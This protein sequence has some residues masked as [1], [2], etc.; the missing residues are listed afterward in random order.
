MNGQEVFEQRLEK[1][2]IEGVGA[3]GPGVG[4]I[5]VDFNKQAVDA[6]GDSGARQQRNKLRLAA[7]D[8]IGCR[9]LLHGV[10]RIEDDGRK[11][12]HDG[13]RAEIDDQVVVAEGGAAL[14]EEDA[15][16]AGGANFLDA[17]THVGRRDELTFFDVDGTAGFSCGYEQ[18]SLTT[19]KRRN[20]EDIDGFGGDLAVGGL[21][22]VSQDGEASIFGD[23]AENARAL[24]QAGPAKTFHAGAVGLVVA[25]F[26]DERN[27]EIGSDALKGVRHGARMGFRL[28]DAGA[29]DEEEAARADLDGADFERGAHEGDSIVPA[30]RV[31]ARSGER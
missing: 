9:W 14:G 15:L 24:R 1:F 25:G 6:C 29:S 20:L 31:N 11:S 4:R 16:V 23:A 27:A 7:A 28:D 18:V 17:V 19:E 12:A 13:E 5:V 21:V 2:E 26:E 8:S 3:I 30:N 22:D 10:G